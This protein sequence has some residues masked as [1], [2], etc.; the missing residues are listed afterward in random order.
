M[1]NGKIIPRVDYANN[2]RVAYSTDVL[3][4][5]FHCRGS[6]GKRWNAILFLGKASASL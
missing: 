6:G 4:I 2:P 5:D 1:V 3:A